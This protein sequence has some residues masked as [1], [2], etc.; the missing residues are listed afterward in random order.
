MKKNRNNSEIIH[1]SGKGFGASHPFIEKKST[2]LGKNPFSDS[3]IVEKDSNSKSKVS[4]SKAFSSKSVKIEE[5]RIRKI[6]REEIEVCLTE[7]ERWYPHTHALDDA[8]KYA[9]GTDSV[10][11]AAD[12]VGDAIV[13]G[14]KATGDAIVSGAKTA[15]D[16]VAITP[17][18]YWVGK[19][20]SGTIEE[21]YEEYTDLGK[22]IAKSYKSWILNAKKAA[23]TRVPG[24]PSRG[25]Y[26]VSERFAR[27]ILPDISYNSVFYSS[28]IQTEDI[29][30]A[31]KKFY[32]P[33]IAISNSAT[34]GWS[35]SSKTLSNYEGTLNWGRSDSGSDPQYAWLGAK[36]KKENITSEQEMLKI[37]AKYAPEN[38]GREI[39]IQTPTDDPFVFESSLVVEDKERSIYTRE[40]FQ[41]PFFGT[42]AIAKR[43]IEK[44]KAGMDNIVAVDSM[45]NAVWRVFYGSRGF[46]ESDITKIRDFQR[47]SEELSGIVGGVAEIIND[48]FPII[49]Y[50]AS[51]AYQLCAF[52]HWTDDPRWI[53]NPLS[54]SL[55]VPGGDLV[56]DWDPTFVANVINPCMTFKMP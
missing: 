7:H 9:T 24:T 34:A 50:G 37:L 26:F 29:F 27:E 14:A 23:G 42:P 18:E 13:S 55:A 21:F 51:E 6:I 53:Q 2:N 44:I 30:D 4:V 17:Y 19:G 54:P 31:V 36:F 56:Y 1:R 38:V 22:R 16:V 20:F 47:F 43:E 40:G 49:N 5:N 28:D 15:A 33:S 12:Q 48:W 52:V 35:E 8:W 10:A 46:P 11:D 25:K 39:K 3:D 32:M 45:G 41:S